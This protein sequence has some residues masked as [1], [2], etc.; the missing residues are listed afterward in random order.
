MACTGATTHPRFAPRR[1]LEWS[2]TLLP[3]ARSSLKALRGPR[4]RIRRD[5]I[6]PVAGLVAAGLALRLWLILRGWPNLDSDMAILGLMARHILYNGAHPLFYY[7]QHYNGPL[8][9]YLPALTFALWGPTT[10]ALNLA[11]LPVLGFFLVAM[12]GVG[13]AAYGR[14]VGLMTLAYLALGPALG[15]LLGISYPVFGVTNGLGALLLLLVYARLRQAEPLP[16]GWAGWARALVHYAAIGLVIGF[17]FWSAPLIAPFA[18][19]AVGALAGGRP[20][21]LRHLPALALVAGALVGCW[22]LLAYNLQHGGVTFVELARQ[23]RAAGQVG[24]LPPLANWAQQIGATLSVA[25]PAVLGSPNVCVGINSAWPTYPAALVA[26]NALLVGPCT[27]LNVLFALGMLACYGVVARQLGRIGWAWWQRQRRRRGSPRSGRSRGRPRVRDDRARLWLRTMLLFVAMSQVALYTLSWT[28]RVYQF[29]AARYLL[30]LYVT[31]P[32]VFGVLWEAARPTLERMAV[33]LSG[34]A[35]AQSAMYAQRLATQGARTEHALDGRRQARSARRTG[36]RGVGRRQMP[37]RF[38][39][40]VA[41]AWPRL[42]VGELALLLVFAAY[43]AVVTAWYAGDTGRFA[44]PELPGDQRL[45]GTLTSHGATRFI[46][47]YWICYRL[48]FE[49]GE[50]LRCAVRDGR[51]GTLTRNGAV[52]R[53]LP[54]LDLI[55]RTA[56]PAYVF[57][58]GSREDTTFESWAA[59]QGLPHVGYVRIVSEGYAIYYFPQQ[60]G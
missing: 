50:R 49:S 1:S 9:A 51:D 43:G 24:P 38:A 26:R 40:W 16:V 56:H 14:A 53:Y 39:R 36:R 32:L 47:D 18:L 30:P 46:S 19:A 3:R 28:A 55:E 58:A 5:E 52:N 25:L 2:A 10:L 54:Y 29:T 11:V 45:I 22:P 59:A 27:A 17:G 21:E 15:L 42:A 44:L 7:G 31:I 13:R 41:L 12:Y 34:Y 20:R 8:D 37:A 48:A 60:S 57:G 33:W 4:S 23:N 6:A 35:H